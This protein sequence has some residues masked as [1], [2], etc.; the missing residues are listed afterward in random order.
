MMIKVAVGLVG[1]NIVGRVE[2]VVGIHPS[3]TH[4]LMSGE[5]PLWVGAIYLFNLQ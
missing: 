1:C 5:W 3:H 4:Q 2:M